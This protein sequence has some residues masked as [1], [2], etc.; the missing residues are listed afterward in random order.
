MNQRSG[1]LTLVPTPISRKYSPSPS[2]IEILQKAYEN[3]DILLV[4]D[5]KPSRQRWT[6]WGLSREAIEK[7]ICYNEQSWEKTLPEVTQKILAGKN[8]VIFS[9]GGL[10]VIADPGR[11]LVYQLRVKG[12][13]INC[14]CFENSFLVALALSGFQNEQFSYLGFPPRDKEERKDFW[15]NAL[16]RKET[17]V[18]MDTGYRLKRVQEE[19]IEYLN[20]SQRT[21]YFGCNLNSDE[22]IEFWG[23]KEQLKKEMIPG[24]HNFVLCI[25]SV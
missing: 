23:T 7:F 24:K 17:L 12:G 2:N 10:P 18:I 13:K 21:L 22:Q 1:T 8:A 11:E 5:L 16:Q 6:S 20:D 9:D 25:S 19:L 15:K 14:G 4:E 3:S